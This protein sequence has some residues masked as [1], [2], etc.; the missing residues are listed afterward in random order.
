MKVKYIKVRR[1]DLERSL[2]EWRKD[3]AI[4]APAPVKGGETDWRPLKDALPSVQPGTPRSSLK[5]FFFPQP[6]T[7]FTFSTRGE[8]AFLLKEP[9]SR[10]NMTILFGV[11][12]CDARS[13]LLNAMPYKNDPYFQEQ[14][15]R[16]AM[17]GI[18]CTERCRTCFCIW[19]GGSPVGTDGLD[20]ALHPLDEDAFLAK[21]L[22]DRGKA[23]AEKGAL[24]GEAPEDG[25]VEKI[26]A[27]I[28][29][30]SN[31]SAS[32]PDPAVVLRE[33]DLL[34]LYN[35]PFW[36][37]TA[38]S[39]IN[40]GTCTFLCP[41][42]YCFDIQD[43]SAKGVGRRIRYWDSC[44]FPLFTLHASGHNPR[45]E[46]VQRVR[47]RFMHKLKYFP[48]RFGP[49]SCVGCGRCIRACPVNIDIREVMKSLL[50]S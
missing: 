46:K 9:A 14:R 31:A 22:T 21:I 48:E 3:A 34:S 6:E 19:A 37:E 36:N 30:A 29:A 26:E 1:T 4:Y 40:C 5:A 43:E 35:A 42:C 27:R 7:L 10:P 23:L 49:L 28:V 24:A 33:K 8:D 16:T 11:R 20:I 38:S 39:C 47:N 25:D 18:T 44:M 13:V 50:S 12:P 15:R 41:T 17:V 32:V 45:G 2:S